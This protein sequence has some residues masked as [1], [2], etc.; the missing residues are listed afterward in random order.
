MA[1][2]SARHKSLH[3]APPWALADRVSHPRPPQIEAQRAL[4]LAA[5]I[6]TVNRGDHMGMITIPYL[7]PSE[8]PREALY[9]DLVQDRVPV[10]HCRERVSM[11]LLIY[12]R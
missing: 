7:V 2:L 5:P 3:Q 8:L 4:F 9:M 11:C 12:V 10:Q 1:A 6:R